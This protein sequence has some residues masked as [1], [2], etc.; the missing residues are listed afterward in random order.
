MKETVHTAQTKKKKKNAV[1]IYERNLKS[2]Q[3]HKEIFLQ[4]IVMEERIFLPFLFKFVK[5]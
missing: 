4:S 2:M 5:L 1:Y 3:F